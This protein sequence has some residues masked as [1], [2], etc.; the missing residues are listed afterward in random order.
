MSSV[1]LIDISPLITTD[2]DVWPGDVPFTREQTCAF[3][4]GDNLDLSAMHTT[5]HLG[6]HAD[7]PSHYLPDAPGIGAR[8]L[9]F[10]YGP[11]EVVEVAVAPGARI[12]L[13]DVGGSISAPRVLF[14]TGSF[15]DPNNWNN[16]FASL[17]PEL[18]NHLVSCGVK[19]VGIDTPSIDP[20]ASKLLESHQAV[21]EHDV[22]VLEGL[23][24]EHVPVGVYTLCA[25]PLKLAEADAAPV[26]AVLISIEG[27]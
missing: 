1:E 10:Y 17:S 7:A 24:L 5:L 27:S 15:P 19:L 23:C 12:G 25:F 18:I 13:A 22:A 6:A 26:R 9:D 4:D 2:I 21:A 20:F 3:S 11:C 16:D 8:A 14:K